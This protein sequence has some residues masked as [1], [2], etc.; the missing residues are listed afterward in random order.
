LMIFSNREI[1][2]LALPPL[3]GDLFINNINMLCR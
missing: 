3:R 1:N 2:P